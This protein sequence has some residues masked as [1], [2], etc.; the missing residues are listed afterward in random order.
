M[1]NVWTGASYAPSPQ[2]LARRMLVALNLSLGDFFSL[3]SGRPT[4]VA[5]T[6]P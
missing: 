5:C 3:L 4:H 2:R 6:E 1:H